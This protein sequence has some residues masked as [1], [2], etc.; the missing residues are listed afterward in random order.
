[1]KGGGAVYAIKHL[2]VGDRITV[3]FQGRGY[4][5]VV[6]DLP[7]PGKLV[8]A[9]PTSRGVYLEFGDNG[10]GEV[11][12]KQR[13]G[14]LTFSVAEESRFTSKGVPMMTLR[15]V[16]EVKRSQRRSWF[17]LEKSLPVELSVKEEKDPENP[18]LMIKA[19]TLN[20][21][22]G[23]CSIAIRQPVDSDTRL[24]CR[25]SLSPG[26]DL[27]VDGQVVWVEKQDGDG[28]A[29]VIG[30]QFVDEDS[31]TQKKL[32]QYVMAEQQKQLRTKR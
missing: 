16:S 17:R 23:G 27:M 21:S 5:T 3:L 2:Q 15:A 4:S 9:R 14:I 7:A 30:V 12:F 25:I 31:D 13:N 11:Y 28:K 26:M 10:V 24:E 22:G 8:V 6:Q 19:R 1:V 29:S 32:V 18:G 20:I